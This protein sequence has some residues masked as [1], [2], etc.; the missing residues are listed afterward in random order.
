MHFMK[1]KMEVEVTPEFYNLFQN[2]ETLSSKWSRVSSSDRGEWEI[3]KHFKEHQKEKT[4]RDGGWQ[5]AFWRAEEN[6]HWEGW[7]NW[8]PE[9]SN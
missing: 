3:F 1:K 6:E 2:S 7:S 4:L 9:I 8:K 5:A